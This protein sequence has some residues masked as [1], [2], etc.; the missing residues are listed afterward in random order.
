MNKNTKLFSHKIDQH[1]DVLNLKQVIK[2]VTQKN[3]SSII[4][5]NAHIFRIN[6]PYYLQVFGRGLV[7]Y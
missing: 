4:P 3:I 2:K 7:K 5:N 1:D 6:E